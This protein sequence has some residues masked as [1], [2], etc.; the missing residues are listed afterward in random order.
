VK[1]G[2]RIAPLQSAGL[3]ER[4]GDVVRLAESKLSVSNEVFVGLMR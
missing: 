2:E 4:E 1:L 3:L